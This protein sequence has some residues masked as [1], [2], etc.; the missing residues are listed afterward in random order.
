MNGVPPTSYTSTP[1]SWANAKP[2][3]PSPATSSVAAG[4]WE[5]D[6]AYCS[7]SNQHQEWR[8]WREEQHHRGGHG[9]RG[10]HPGAAVVKEDRAHSGYRESN[11]AKHQYWS[12][13][14]KGVDEHHDGHHHHRGYHYSQRRGASSSQQHFVGRGGEEGG[15]HGYHDSNGRSYGEYTSYH[16]RELRVKCSTEVNVQDRKHREWGSTFKL[17]NIPARISMEELS[18]ILQSKGV[19]E[20]YVENFVRGGVV[21]HFVADL[22]T[23]VNILKGLKIDDCFVKKEP[24]YVKPKSGPPYQGRRNVENNNDF[25]T[26]VTGTKVPVAVEADMV[27]PSSPSITSNTCPA[28]PPPKLPLDDSSDS[29]DDEG[30][31]IV[32]DFIADK[33]L[34]DESKSTNR[35][36]EYAKLKSKCKDDKSDQ[37]NTQAH[38]YTQTLR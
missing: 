10:N 3:F 2:W 31:I 32:E 21:V 17:S 18:S 28:V 15:G 20:F 25:P 14:G 24:V 22:Q 27:R 23:V 33:E 7:T 34:A 9:Y 5:E 1:E 26:C 16:R 35:S 11:L 38:R 19:G 6:L 36:N 29:S 37:D 4:R 13:I 12:P 30:V 8:G